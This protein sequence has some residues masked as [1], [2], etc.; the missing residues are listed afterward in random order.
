MAEFGSAKQDPPQG[1]DLLTRRAALGKLRYV[2]P[3]IAVLEVLR[4][5]VAL[6]RSGPATKGK[7]KGKGKG[8]SKQRSKRTLSTS[9]R[10]SGSRGPRLR[11]LRPA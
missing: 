5:E 6:G 8:K 9:T 4:P 3:A 7:A 1:A 2:P 10:D 11:L